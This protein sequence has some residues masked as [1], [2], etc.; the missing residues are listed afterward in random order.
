VVLGVQ[1][2]QVPRNAIRGIGR[3]TSEFV[4]A[5]AERQPQMV[6]GITVDK[7][8][9]LPEFLRRLPCEVPVLDLAERP[10]V[11]AH[12]Q[13]LFHVFSVFDEVPLERIWP[14]WAQNPSVG[15]VVTMHDIHPVQH[16]GYPLTGAARYLRDS[17]YRFVEQADTIM[18][19]WHATAVDVTGLLHVDPRRIFVASCGVKDRCAPGSLDPVSV[20]EWG[21]ELGLQPDYLFTAGHVDS[22]KYL[23]ALIRA[24]A[25]LA[26]TIRDRHQLVITCAHADRSFLDSFD[27]EAQMLGVADRIVIRPF[28]KDETMAQLYRNCRA[29]VFPCLGEELGLPVLRALRYGVPTIVSDVAPLREI[30]RDADA[31]FNPSYETDI[32]RALYR[33]I[34]DERFAESR[35]QAGEREVARYSWDSWEEAVLAGYAYAARRR[36]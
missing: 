10:P 20:A 7:E 6:A 21:R 36:P 18:T 26:A 14:H 19:N 13:L 2:S 15:L 32:A 35:R 28:V 30:V 27:Q 1:G 33:V 34:T 8:L 9:P 23:L 16:P 5:M 31:R 22:W 17:R 11:S 3:L 29:F 12:D 4:V 24:Y 25:S